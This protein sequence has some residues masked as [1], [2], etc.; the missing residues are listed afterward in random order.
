MWK[1]LPHSR[2]P[3]TSWRWLV[4]PV[5]HPEGHRTNLL[6]PLPHCHRFYQILRRS[7]EGLGWGVGGESGTTT[8]KKKIN[9]KS[10]V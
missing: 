2:S 6:R 3:P 9:A 8:L 1:N 4:P 10:V 5:G 7:G